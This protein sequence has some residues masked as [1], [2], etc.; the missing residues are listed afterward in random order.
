MNIED[1]LDKIDNYIKRTATFDFLLGKGHR[2]RIAHWRDISRHGHFNTVNRSDKMLFDYV[3]HL[4]RTK[5][6]D[7][8]LLE[9][10]NQIL[11]NPR[12]IETFNTYAHYMIGD[13]LPHAINL[14]KCFVVVAS[15]IPQ[16]SVL[17]LVS[18][19]AS[20][21]VMTVTARIDMT[22]TFRDNRCCIAF[23]GLAE[24]CPS[25]HKEEFMYTVDKSQ[26]FKTCLVSGAAFAQARVYVNMLS[27][28]ATAD[29]LR[30]MKFSDTWRSI[31]K[32]PNLR[33]NLYE[34]DK[35]LIP[36]LDF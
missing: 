27:E 26:Y 30:F 11:D 14:D 32:T 10:F 15:K 12:V 9:G 20:S 22:K 25:G 1:K 7:D 34:K 2:K 28:T 23:L 8:E 18:T 21:H 4:E 17:D 24:R 19:I 29:A 35:R 36:A 33:D 6:H 16:G 5:H 13:R 31:P 3:G